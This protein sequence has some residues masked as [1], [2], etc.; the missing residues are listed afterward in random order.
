[1][2]IDPVDHHQGVAGGA[3][4]V[5]INVNK[6][7]HT[8]IMLGSNLTFRVTKGV[9]V[10]DDRQRII[11]C[12]FVVWIVIDVVRIALIVEPMKYPRIRNAKIDATLRP[13]TV[14]G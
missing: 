12:N 6:S 11:G 5:V 4:S 8:R 13:A 3:V 1:M 10:V 7:K 9:D 2:S 14:D